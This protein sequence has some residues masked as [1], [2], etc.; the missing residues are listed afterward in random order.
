MIN[1]QQQT[2]AKPQH[3]C[4][5][6]LTVH[7]ESVRRAM[8]WRKQ[9]DV[10]YIWNLFFLSPIVNESHISCVQIFLIDFFS[11]GCHLYTHSSE[12]PI[13]PLQYCACRNV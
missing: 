4:D 1:R 8:Y 11:K 6:D 13:A 7:E 12:I 9:E 5:T 3:T 10:L 2:R